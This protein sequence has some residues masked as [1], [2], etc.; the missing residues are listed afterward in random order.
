MD[1]LHASTAAGPVAIVEVEPFALEHECANAILILKSDAAKVN[2][3][4]VRQRTCG[5]ETVRR[6]CRGMVVRVVTMLSH[7]QQFVVRISSTVVEV[8]ALSRCHV[9]TMVAQVNS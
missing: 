3:E 7:I 2:F 8:L 9:Q 6:A 1:L 4:L 5:F